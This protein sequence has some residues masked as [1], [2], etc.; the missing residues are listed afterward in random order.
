[1]LGLKRCSHPGSNL[2]HLKQ[3]L[4]SIQTLTSKSF[5]MKIEGHPNECIQGAHALFMMWFNEPWHIV[6]IKAVSPWE[7]E[8][9]RDN[10]WL[11][12]IQAKLK[13]PLKGGKPC[14]LV[15]SP[16]SL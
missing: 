11:F 13:I 5:K 2:Y 8:K 1:M 3:N 9:P 14:D 10:Q 7:R 4:V 15:A 12:T 16:F 6:L